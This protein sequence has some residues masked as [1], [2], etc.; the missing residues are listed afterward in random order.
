[1]L[2]LT[3]DFLPWAGRSIS[4]LSDEN[5]RR[6][7]CTEHVLPLRSHICFRFEFQLCIR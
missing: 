4:N 5:A 2:I 3:M 7:E 6:E 1:M